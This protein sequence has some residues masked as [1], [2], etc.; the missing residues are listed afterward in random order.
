M[1]LDEAAKAYRDA[2]AR[3]RAAQEKIEELTKAIEET[4]KGAAT[5]GAETALANRTL[6]ETAAVAR[7]QILLCHA[8]SAPIDT[9]PART[10]E[11][12]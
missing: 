10:R 12:K 7:P 3:E 6:V 9:Q 8:C 5:A 4:R 11:A 1:T 2:M